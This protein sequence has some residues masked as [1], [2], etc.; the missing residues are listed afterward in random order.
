[1]PP[2]QASVSQVLGPPP[3]KATFKFKT[4][5]RREWDFEQ[6]I[7]EIKHWVVGLQDSDTREHRVG[8][9]SGGKLEF[10]LVNHTTVGD[11]LT[12]LKLGS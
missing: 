6:K 7:P 10:A 5:W 12:E 8:D 4:T 2:E 3:V 9:I 1:M 11:S